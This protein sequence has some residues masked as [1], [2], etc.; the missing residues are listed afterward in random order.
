MKKLMIVMGLLSVMLFGL[1][2]QKVEPV[3]TI[4]PV[5]LEESLKNV[6]VL[7]FSAT[8]P[9]QITINVP[10]DLDAVPVGVSIN[11]NYIEL[12]GSHSATG[13]MNLVCNLLDADGEYAGRSE[14]MP[15]TS[16]QYT[17]K[18]SFNEIPLQ[19]LSRI[20]KYTCYLFLDSYG[21]GFF[22]N[23]IERVNAP[24]QGNIE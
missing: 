12:H 19:T 23:V 5:N 6:K 13:A 8:K 1:D 17:A 2:L 16:G 7:K 10:V 22:S 24:V 18:V 14:R 4:N 3:A 21:P 11:S 20:S 9:A 15:L